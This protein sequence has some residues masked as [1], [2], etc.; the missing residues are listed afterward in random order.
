MRAPV[1]RLIVSDASERLAALHLGEDDLRQAGA[2]EV[3]ETV[4][5]E[6]F[7]VEVEFAPEPAP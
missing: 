2:I 4:V 1:A 7:S 6:E 5:G 3:I